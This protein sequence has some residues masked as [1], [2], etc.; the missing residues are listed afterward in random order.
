MTNEMMDGMVHVMMDAMGLAVAV[1]I[2]NQQARDIH[3][4]HQHW[5]QQ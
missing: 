4:N 1:G 2:D 5:H 3:H